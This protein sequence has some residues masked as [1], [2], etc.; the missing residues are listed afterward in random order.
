MHP[1]V[2]DFLAA[3]HGQVRGTHGLDVGGRNVN[4]TGRDLWPTL[5]WTTL[6]AMPGEDVDIVA[7]A[8]TWT[9]DRA[10]DLVICTEVLEHAEAWRDI[11]ATC[12]RALR[13]G[14]L[15]LLTCATHGRDPHS[16]HD[17]GPV[18]PGEH[19]GNVDPDDLG[20]A[21]RAA[22][23]KGEV[24]AFHDRGDVYAAARRPSA[25]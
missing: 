6:D 11:V 9:P 10:Y 16:A 24:T 5:T 19:Y 22:G 13:P 25:G 1:P 15:L 18:R 8:A 20:D 12:A 14:G 21:L 7:D 4:G 23:L 2:M 17:G 3:H